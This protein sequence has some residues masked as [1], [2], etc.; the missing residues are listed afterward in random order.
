MPTQTLALVGVA[1]GAGTTRLAIE[2]GGTLA[3]A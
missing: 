1:G 2:C 3:R